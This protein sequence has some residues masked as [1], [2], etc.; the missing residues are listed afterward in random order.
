MSEEE[1]EFQ[2][3]IT[4]CMASLLLGLETKLEAALTAMARIN[5][6]GMEMVR[7]DLSAACHCVA[8]LG[9]LGALLLPLW[10]RVSNQGVHV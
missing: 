5:W 9:Q 8:W 7:A 10:S 1:D 4:L 3:V 6:A 2:T